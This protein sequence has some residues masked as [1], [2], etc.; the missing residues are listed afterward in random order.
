MVAELSKPVDPHCGTPDADAVAVDIEHPVGS[1]HHDGDR[2][3][4]ATIGMPAVGAGRQWL[5]GS[6]LKNGKNQA[7]IGGIRGLEGVVVTDHDGSA[8]TGQVKELLGELKR[9]ADAPVAGGMTR[10]EPRVKGDSVPSEPLHVGHGGVVIGLGV[11]VGALLENREDTRRGGVSGHAAADGG[12]GH[13]DA[14]AVDIHDLLGKADQDHDRAVRGNA[15]SPPVLSGLEWADWLS[16]RCSL[17]VE[18]RFLDIDRAE[19][20]GTK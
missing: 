19:R 8:L 18:G 6:G 14:V 11:V 5:S 20:E 4:L 15:G 9:K 1:A 2:T 16:G 12:T 17:G 13:Q 10:Q 3:R 7:W